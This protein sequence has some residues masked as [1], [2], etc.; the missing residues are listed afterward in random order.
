[1][2]CRWL[3]LPSG[4]PYADFQQRVPLRRCLQVPKNGARKDNMRKKN[5]FFRRLDMSPVYVRG[6]ISLLDFLLSCLTNG[7][8]AL[9]LRGAR[10]VGNTPQ[11]RPRSSRTSSNSAFHSLPG[12]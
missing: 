6:V 12:C 4:L 9:A 1:M 2:G 10:S 8:R 11:C 5:G 7:V 3:K